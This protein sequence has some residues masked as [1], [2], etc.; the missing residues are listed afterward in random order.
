MP[1]L[2]VPGMPG[3]RSSTHP[4]RPDL[5]KLQLSPPRTPRAPKK[6]QA[7]RTPRTWM[8]RSRGHQM[9]G[10]QQQQHTHALKCA[11]G[12][13]SSSSV[14]SE[15]PP[16]PRTALVNM[17]LTSFSARFCVS[18]ACYARSFRSSMRPPPHRTQGVIV[19]RERISPDLLHPLRGVHLY[20][21]ICASEIRSR[22]AR[23]MSL[24]S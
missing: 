2:C 20:S 11:N 21:E 3:I 16:T 9:L 14:S 18:V 23:S 22:I 19:A 4:E 17:A 13:Q 24:R 12:A 8:R 6:S 15:S 1:A 10:L 7:S 5:H